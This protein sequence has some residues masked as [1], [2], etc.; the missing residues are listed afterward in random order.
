MYSKEEFINIRD[1]FPI[2]ERNI[3][4]RPCIYLDN[5]ATT[6][7]P[8]KVI[9]AIE[10]YYK[11]INSNV[12]RG[13]HYLSQKATE[14][15]EK[16]R[17]K[18]QKFICA[19]YSNEIIFTRGTTEAINLVASGIMPFIK[20]GDEI[21]V[22]QMEHHSNI[23]PWQIIC[24]VTGALL[25]VIPLDN[26]NQLC[27]E[28]FEK[29][30]SDKVKILAISHI[31]N[32]LGIVTPIQYFIKKA[33]QYGII[34]L[35]DGAQAV[36]NDYVNVQDLETDFYVFSAHKMYG[37]T[38]V[39]VLYGKESFLEKLYPLHGGGEMIKEVIFKKTTYA[40]LPFRQEAG[41][42]NIEGIIALSASI[43]F[44]KQIRMKKIKK[45]EKFLLDRTI[46][47]LKNIKGILLYADNEPRSGI[48][49]FNLKDVHSFDVGSILDQLGIAVRTGYHCAQ[50][51]MRF[52]GVN[53]TVRV[54]FCVYNNDEEV[55]HLCE[56]IL[57]AKKMLL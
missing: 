9:K 10:D 2:L 39:G 26:K 21:I 43:D 23:V 18:I 4:G 49:S 27:I 45:H 30:L 16:S 34:T 55:D 42:P 46:D 6:Q 25:K 14:T 8:K 28:S 52:L 17:I 31:S 24:Q 57:K 29:L 37:P 48:I 36:C 13:T 1:Q 54:S 47:G 44:I 20:E 12:H 50:P 33:H 35:I 5:A 40:D 32:V 53:G 19:E 51:L 41:T 15:M 11:E 38:G 56:G 3:Y 22:S 7:K